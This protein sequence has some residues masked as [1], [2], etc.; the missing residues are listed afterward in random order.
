[1]GATILGVLLTL[2]GALF[3]TGASL[4]ALVRRSG[5]AVQRRPVR[6]RDAGRGDKRPPRAGQR[7]CP[8]RDR[9][10][11]P[12][13]DLA[14]LD[15]PVDAVQDYP[16][17]VSAPPPALVPGSKAT[18]RP[19]RREGM[20]LE[21]PAQPSEYKLPDRS[22]LRN[23]RTGRPQC[24]ANRRIAEA[25]VQCLANFGV[26]ATVDRA[27]RRPARHPL[28]APARARDQGRQRSRSSR[29]TSRMRWRRPRSASWRRFPASRRSGSRCRTSRRTSSRS[30]TSSATCRPRRARSR[31]GS[32]RTS[33]APPSRPTSRGCRTS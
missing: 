26:E 20:L 2:I 24:R 17:I 30:A 21:L 16:D 4:G 25:L 27:D 6:P 28:R 7:C 5:R 12:P 31:S 32:A 11:S 22:L 23:R 13:V 1:M 8:S 19:R 33:P 14:S 18:I 10:V 29:T 3:L 9:H 15:A